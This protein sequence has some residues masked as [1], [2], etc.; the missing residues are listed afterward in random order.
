MTT[1]RPDN[2]QALHSGVISLFHQQCRGRTMSSKTSVASKCC[3]PIVDI[4]LE[5]PR[6][7]VPPCVRVLLVTVDLEPPPLDV[8]SALNWGSPS[9]CALALLTEFGPRVVVSGPVMATTARKLARPLQ[10]L[11]GH[12]C[13]SGQVPHTVHLTVLAR[14]ELQLRSLGPSHYG[15]LRHS[16]SR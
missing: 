11:V 5:L 12:L 7:V 13:V 14:C 15:A 1:V 10:T 4:A 9:H 3:Y 2:V 6:R 16:M 8:P